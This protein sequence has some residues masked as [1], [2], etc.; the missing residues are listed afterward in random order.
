MD[1]EQVYYCNGEYVKIYA[2]VKDEPDLFV[3]KNESGYGELSVVHRNGLTK[4]EDSY[5]YKQQQKKADEL[6]M[7]TAKA[8]EN[9]DAI[10]EKVIAK[11]ISRLQSRMKM[12]IVFG[13]DMGNSAGW[14][15]TIV[16][17]LEKLIKEV[18]KDEVK[19]EK[20]PF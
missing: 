20:D 13:K 16:N 19:D 15:M 8:Q 17:E 11:A 1:K 5:E 7:I 10:V 2:E 12:N 9:F 18:A 3:I 6:R 14:A 4:K